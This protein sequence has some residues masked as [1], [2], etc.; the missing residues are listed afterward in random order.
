LLKWLYEHN[1]KVLYAPGDHE[2]V[3]DLPD[4]LAAF[5][6]SIKQGNEFMTV[7]GTNFLEYKDGKWIGPENAN[8]TLNQ[9]KMKLYPSHLFTINGINI[10]VVQ[11]TQ[12]E[13]LLKNGNYKTANP[14]ESEAKMK[15][16]IKS[17]L[18]QDAHAI[19]VISHIGLPPDYDQY[20]VT[21]LIKKLPAAWHKFL[22]FFDGNS[23]YAYAGNLPKEKSLGVTV[24]WEAKAGHEYKVTN[25]KFDGKKF[26]SDSHDVFYSNT[27]K[28]GAFVG[29]YELDF[30]T[31]YAAKDLPK[32]RKALVN[33]AGA[34][35]P[36]SSYSLDQDVLDATGL[37]KCD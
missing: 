1:V 16:E 30:D 22:V 8:F 2:L 18:A 19:F 5:K 26:D 35:K 7:V 10:G 33:F 34:I 17:L 20:R 21:E 15:T 3:S 28:F 24:P 36:V 4:S 13:P 29:S 25:T 14:S 12:P 9:N 32:D 6:N 27:G 37:K 11:M 23:H 31:T